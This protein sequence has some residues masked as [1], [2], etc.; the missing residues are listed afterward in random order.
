MD[1][2]SLEVWKVAFDLSIKIYNITLELPDHELYGISNQM[3]RASVSLVSNIAEGC[4][5]H[6]KNDKLKFFLMARGSLYELETQLEISAGIGYL[7]SNKLEQLLETLSKSL[8]LL[9]GFIRYHRSLH[10]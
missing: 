5:R 2:K 6:H 3:R 1:Y 4:G 8:M 7:G 9:E 10:E